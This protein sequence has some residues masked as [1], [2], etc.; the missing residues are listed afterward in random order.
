MLMINSDVEDRVW[1]DRAPGIAVWDVVRYYGWF[2]VGA[3]G[4]P[5]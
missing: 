2:R 5:F 3:G 4:I 1:G